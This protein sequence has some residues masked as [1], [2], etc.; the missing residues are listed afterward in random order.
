MSSLTSI[1]TVILG[2]SGYTG[3]E[4]VRLLAPHPHVK[5]K[6]L[7]AETQAGKAM[8]EIYPHLRVLDLPVTVKNNEVDYTRIDVVFCCL[9]HGITQE[10]IA[11]LPEHVR[12]VDLS[13]DF[14]LTNIEGYHEWYGHPHRAVEQQKQAV[15][16]LT[17]WSREQVK[18]AR[19]VAN[20]GCYPTASLLPLLPLVKEKII[21]AQGICIDA[22]SGV[23]GAGRAAKQSNLFTEITEGVSAYGIGH[24][25]HVPEIEQELSRRAGEEVVVSFTPHL[26][27]M[28]RGML[29]T[30][31]A[32]LIGNA[33][34]KKARESLQAYYRDEAFVHVLNDGEGSPSTHQ[35]RGTNH[36]MI[37]VH[38]GRIKNELI[39]ISVIDNVTK[40]AS[41]Q[42]VQNMNV[43]FGFPEATALL[44]VALV[45]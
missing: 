23:S 20:P 26:V 19:L 5:I 33:T 44:G 28:S 37:S 21:N 25:R 6:A 11:G 32:P 2:A 34:V 17:E 41:G 16:G 22:M 31:H 45:P 35:V 39:I 15:Y 24:H 40:G 7:T 9:P 38:A 14:R 18:T 30:I 29:A 27:P 36:C 1:N 4:L 8:A 42:A 3:A 10:I 43:M 12:I 13:A